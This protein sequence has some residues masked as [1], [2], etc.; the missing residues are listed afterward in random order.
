MAE[1]A[2]AAAP[3]RHEGRGMLLGFI[4]V[5][6]FSLTLPATR[7]AVVEMDPVVVGLGRAILAAGVALVILLVTRQRLPGA[8]GVSLAHQHLLDA[9]HDLGARMDPPGRLHRGGDLHRPGDLGE[10]GPGHV[11]GHRGLP[12]RRVGVAGHLVAAPAGAAEHQEQDQG[13]EYDGGRGS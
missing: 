12:G 7:I 1:S 2:P 5:A 4:G 9:P 8:D 13:R 11:D 6:V 3:Q 10:P